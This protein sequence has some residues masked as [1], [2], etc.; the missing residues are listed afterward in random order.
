MKENSYSKDQFFDESGDILC[1]L[2]LHGNFKRIN[3]TT[4][5]ILG[6]SE[7]DLSSK[8]VTDF[9]HEDDLKNTDEEIVATAKSLSQVCEYVR[10]GEEKYAA[11][12]CE[13]KTGNQTETC[14]KEALDDVIKAFKSFIDTTPA[15]RT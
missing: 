12:Y 8:P 13:M 7:D 5:R 3:P 10:L 11:F 15:I 6:Y 2:D 14:D 9:I 4:R 1:V